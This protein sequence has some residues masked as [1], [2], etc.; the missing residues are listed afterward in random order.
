MF[1]LSN[2][3]TFVWSVLMPEWEWQADPTPPESFQDVLDTLMDAVAQASEEAPTDDAPGA[4]ATE[5]GPGLPGGSSLLQAV[6]LALASLPQEESQAHADG[7]E[8]LPAAPAAPAALPAPPPPPAMVV[9]PPAVAKPVPKAVAPAA[10]P[11]PA[12][13]HWVQSGWREAIAYNLYRSPIAERAAEQATREDQ[14]QVMASARRR[15][16]PDCGQP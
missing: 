6:A 3:T 4:D 14:E 16:K 2:T 9:P 5:A 13:G 7:A 1:Y 11:A 8:P 10:T 12:S 15:R